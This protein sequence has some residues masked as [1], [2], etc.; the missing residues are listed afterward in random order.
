MQMAMKIVEMRI[1]LRRTAPNP[2]VLG[3]GSGCASPRFS[4][5]PQAYH[6]C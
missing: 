2:F 1:M 5:A 4:Q 3:P 6:Q